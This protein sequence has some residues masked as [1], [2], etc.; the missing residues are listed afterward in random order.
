MIIPKSE[1]QNTFKVKIVL[2]DKMLATKVLQNMQ[3][4]IDIGWRNSWNILPGKEKKK[5]LCTF[6]IRLLL[7]FASA[8]CLFS[9]VKKLYY[10]Y[11]VTCSRYNLMFSVFKFDHCKQ[12]YAW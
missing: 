5:S 1:I 2:P 12:T 6:G 10:L 7:E 11:N 8:A 9:Q 3:L 4:V